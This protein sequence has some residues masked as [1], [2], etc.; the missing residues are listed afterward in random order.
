MLR[1]L[2]QNLIM[3]MPRF[4]WTDL[5]DILI[6]AYIIYKAIRLVKETRAEQLI[7]G[8]IV[9][10]VLLQLS[11]TFKLNTI[12]FLI[13]NAMQF[14][15]IAVL[16]VFQPELR[17][18]L[19][20]VGRSKLS[21]IFSFDASGEQD[22]DKTAEAIVNACTSLSKDRIGALIVIEKETKLGEIVRTGIPLNS[23]VSTEL[24]IN[25]FIP[26]TP[27]HDGAVIIRDNKILSAASF[28]PLTADSTLSME[29]GTRHRAAIGMS[30]NSDAFVIVVSEETGKISLA[31][32]GKL[33]R[34]I[35][36]EKLLYLLSKDK[37]Q[38]SVKTAEK[39]KSKL[40]FWNKDKK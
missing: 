17:R 6:V 8:I 30:E 1:E 16:I 13:Q 34:G 23:D 7:K 20:K 5:V 15:V 2:F 9:L 18:A 22:A 24:L 37:E 39:M 3:N 26:N 32:E 11:H 12:K 33:L 28:L 19:E 40:I 25:I 36:S 14:G 35:S 38:A 29:L 10:I 21:N 4:Y 27:L 31:H